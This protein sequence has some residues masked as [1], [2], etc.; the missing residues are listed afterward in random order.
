MTQEL[1]SKGVVFFMIRGLG[2]LAGFVFTLMITNRYGPEVNGMLALSISVFIIGSLIPRWGFD[3]NLVKIFAAK[4][5][6]EAKSLYIKALRFSTLVSVGIA[7]LG[8]LF[9]SSL[10]ELLNISDKRY[11]LCGLIAVPLWTLINL[12]AGVL[13]GFKNIKLFSFLTTSGR[14][15]LAIA[16]FSLIYFVFGFED[17]H[18]PVVAHTIALALLCGLSFF[19]VHKHLKDTPMVLNVDWKTFIKDSSPMMITLGFM[20][21]LNWTDTVLLSI[22]KGT[23]EAGIF[24]VCFLLASF[25]GFS[26]HA[27]NSILAPKIAKLFM[28]EELDSINRLVGFTFVLNL[29]WASF[30]FILLLLF[31]RPI[32]DFFGPEFSVGEMALMVLAVGQFFNAVC[33]PVGVV[34][35][36]TGKQKL[37]RNL[38]FWA[39][40]CNL[41]LSLILVPIYGLKGAA[42]SCAAGMS[43]W[44]I[45]GVYLVWKHRKIKLVRGF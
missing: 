22:F 25:I 43:I 28:A 7:V 41:I 42:I 12:N 4:P 38:V 39:F 45:V 31:R 32:L 6:S 8:F 11:L 24:N 5:V 23:G 29:A 17:S 26:L 10:T 20:L 44:N 27:L 3:I 14:Y 9:A 21:F 35:Q 15:I 37:F 40:L 2:L 30:I 33:G 16:A 13:R 36:M 1:L 34:L 19:S 18:W